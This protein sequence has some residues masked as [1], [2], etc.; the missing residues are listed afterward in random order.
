MGGFSEPVCAT[1]GTRTHGPAIHHEAALPLAR[2]VGRQPAF[3]QFRA[4][5]GLPDPA[6]GDRVMAV[7][8]NR[9][10][11]PSSEMSDV[12]ITLLGSLVGRVQALYA[13]GLGSK[14]I[15]HLLPCLRDTD[16]GPSE[17]AAPRLVGELTAER[18]RIDRMIS[19][20]IRSREV[21]SDVID[22]ALVGLDAPR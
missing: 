18:D 10:P 2:T 11:G 12:S 8:R 21:L 7:S 17:I 22:T 5:G 16:G 20:L 15:A 6:S 19:D 1:A 4:L 14:R 3:G 13:A 9:G